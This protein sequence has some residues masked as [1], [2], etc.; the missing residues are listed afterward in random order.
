VGARGRRFAP[1]IKG[2][3]KWPPYDSRQP[4]SRKK[5]EDAEFLGAAAGSSELFSSLLV[6]RLHASCN[7]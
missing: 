6:S 4:N 5:R 2:V 1:K 3:G 7:K